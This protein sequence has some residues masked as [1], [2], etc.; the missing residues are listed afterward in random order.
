MNGP[1][2][3]ISGTE[4]PRGGGRAGEV[5]LETCGMKSKNTPTYTND[6]AITEHARYAFQL[7]V[8]AKRSAIYPASVVIHRHLVVDVPDQRYPHLS[9][10]VSSQHVADE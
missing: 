8:N 10:V 3:C 6:V 4:E 5:P 7:S 2:V 1:G 9:R